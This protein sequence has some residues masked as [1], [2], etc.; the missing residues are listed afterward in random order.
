MNNGRRKWPTLDVVNMFATLTADHWSSCLKKAYLSGNITK[1]MAWRYGFQ[2]GLADAGAKGISSEELDKWVIKRCMNLEK[3]ARL[4]LKK[5]HPMPKI[6]P[7]ND[8]YSLIPVIKA[9]KKKR[10]ME[11]SNFIQK[12]NF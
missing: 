12:S 2:A 11:F 5:K 7:K 6:D 1:L 4:I 10:D 9:A 3:C 8:K